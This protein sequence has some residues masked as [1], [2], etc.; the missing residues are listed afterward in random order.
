MR[1]IDTSTVC[2][3]G[4]L[5]LSCPRDT[6][7]DI[8]SAVYGR[9]NNDVC[10]VEGGTNVTNCSSENAAS[11]IDDRYNYQVYYNPGAMEIIQLFIYP[12]RYNST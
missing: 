12:P 11:I 4:T 9:L 6:S 1:L 3:N 10:P 2:E 7:L 8:V 5:H